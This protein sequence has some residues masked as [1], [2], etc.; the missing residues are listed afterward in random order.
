MFF[1]LAGGCFLL[2][3]AQI[4]TFGWASGRFVRRIRRATFSALLR[5]EVGFFDMPEN[6]PG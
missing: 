1:L 5:Q 2:N 4:G 6:S 3:V